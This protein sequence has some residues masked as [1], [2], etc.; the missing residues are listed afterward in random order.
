MIQKREPLTYMVGGFVLCGEFNPWQE[1]FMADM[2]DTAI[3]AEKA[4]LMPAIAKFL[5]DRKVI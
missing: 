1:R 5:V 2:A 4:G 3:S